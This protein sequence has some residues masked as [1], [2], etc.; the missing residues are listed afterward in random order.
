M[1]TRTKEIL[2]ASES[3]LLGFS[4]NRSMLKPIQRLFIYP[5]VYLKVGFGDFTKPMA[6]WSLTSFS[7]LVVLMLFS[8]S[9]EMP[10]ELFLLLSNA[11]AW[12]ILLLTTFLTPSTYAF[13]GAT[14]ASVHRVVDILNRNG[15]QTEEEVELF[16]SNM[17][18][19]EQR[20]ESRVKFYKW[21]IGSFWGLYLLLL[22]F[23][24]RF[25]SLSG[26]PVD[27]ELLNKGFDNFL[28]VILFTAFALIA[29]VSYKRASN[30][31]IANLQYACVEQKSRSKAA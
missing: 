5:L 29:M 16:E 19:V 10:K 9:L 1:F 3:A 7:V 25:L 15:V 13:Y 28:Y 21:I 22:N 14:E 18:K 27:D 20:I 23:Q 24:L 26:K 6:V 8:S 17:E 11:C 4:A 2:E 30:M 12:G 31:L